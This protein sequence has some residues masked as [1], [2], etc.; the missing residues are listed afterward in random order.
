MPT[1]LRWSKSTITF[2][3]TDHPESFPWPG[4]YPLVVDPIIGT[5]R[6]TKV[7]MD[8]GNR[9]NIM[10]TETLNDISIDRARIRPIGAP[11][12]SI[13]LGKLAVPLWQIDVP[14]PSGIRPIIGRRPL[15]SRWS[16]S[17]GPNTPS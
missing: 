11:F 15:P 13:V 5:K 14:T 8:G 17:M 16:C 3:W 6:L 4:R 10:Y 7:L 9:L 12:H 1:L 2:D